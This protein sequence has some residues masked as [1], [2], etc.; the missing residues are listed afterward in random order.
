[1]SDE[2]LVALYP[3][4]PVDHDNRARYLGWTNRELL[5]DWC[6]ECGRFHEPPAPICP[7]CWSTNIK[8]TK[9]EGRGRIHM[10]IFLHQ[11]PRAE[12]VDYSTP[13]PV[14]VVE[15]DEQPGLRWTGTVVGAPNDE[16]DIGER[17]ELT[18]IE[19]AGAPR[20]AFRLVGS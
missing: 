7:C 4:Q 9:V 17:V 5:F 18:W 3:D 13:Y 6:V 19:R 16:I 15:L 10:A 14:V 11:G 2:D 12:G 8:P 1:M 20:P